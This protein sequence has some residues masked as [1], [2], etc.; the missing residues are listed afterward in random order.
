MLVWCYF[1]VPAESCHPLLYDRYENQFKEFGK[2]A[3]K[4]GKIKRIQNIQVFH[5]TGSFQTFLVVPDY[6]HMIDPIWLVPTKSRDQG[7]SNDTNHSVIILG[8]VNKIHPLSD[9]FLYNYN[10]FCTK[11]PL[12]LDISA[13][14]LNFWIL[15]PYSAIYG[16]K[17]VEEVQIL[18]YLS[19]YQWPILK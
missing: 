19:T 4:I 11:L 5:L 6:W 17:A 2:D 9:P 15:D 18:G 12:F 8:K 7:Q 14:Y 3:K 1:K 10:Y 13:V 16:W